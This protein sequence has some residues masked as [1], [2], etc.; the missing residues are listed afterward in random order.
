MREGEALRTLAWI[1]AQEGDLLAAVGAAVEARRLRGRA[2]AL[3]GECALRFPE[4]APACREAARTLVTVA[5]SEVS[6][7]DLRRWFGGSETPP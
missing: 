2:L 6:A 5:G 3:Y 1:A 4:E 7:N